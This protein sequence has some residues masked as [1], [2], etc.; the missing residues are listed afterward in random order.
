MSKVS[1]TMKKR[2]DYFLCCLY[3]MLVDNGVLLP[4]ETYD[5]FKVIRVQEYIDSVKEQKESAVKSGELNSLKEMYYDK[6]VIKSNE[7]SDLYLYSIEYSYLLENGEH[8][9]L[10]DPVT[11]EEERLRDKYIADLIEKQKKTLDS[12]IDYL[13]SSDSDDI[14]M[15]VKIWAFHGMLTM[16]TFN[17]EF[18]KYQRRTKEMMLPFVE[19]DVEI[20]KK[21]VFFV[22]RVLEGY[23]FMDSDLNQI[24]STFNFSKIYGNFIAD[25]IK[26]VEKKESEL[27][28]GIWVRYLIR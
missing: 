6:Y 1:G 25:K 23:S 7:V 18:K 22:K 8:I 12:W 11:L 5:S 26:G 10:V 27:A 19:L 16:G 14:E 28:D 2:T 20:L 13:L 4:D 24:I 3:D 17:L 15:W 21:C 9:N